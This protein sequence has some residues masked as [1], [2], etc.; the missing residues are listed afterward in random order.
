MKSNPLLLL[1]E[2]ATSVCSIALADGDRILSMRTST[3][4]REHA[5]M[6][7]IY[8]QE[9]MEESG[10]DLSQLDAVV[11]SKGPGSYTGLRIGVA[12]AKGI[13]F[14]LDKPLIAIDTPLA[15]AYE[16]LHQQKNEFSTNSYLIPVIDARR[17]EVYGAAINMEMEYNQPIRAEVLHEESFIGDPEAIYYVFGDAAEKCKAVYESQSL[18]KV[19]TEYKHS[20]F[21]LLYPGLKAWNDQ[22]FENISVFEPYYLK[23]FVAKVKATKTKTE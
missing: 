11:V 10:K 19:D 4:E 20:A 5:S 1:L 17:M 22:A 16:Y 13:C 23:E 6:L 8:I 2:T 18:V 15:M 14:S 3:E 12:T 7:T 21:G 9:V